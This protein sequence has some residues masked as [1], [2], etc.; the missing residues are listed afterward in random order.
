MKIPKISII[1]VSYNADQYIERTINSIVNQ[2][3]TDIEYLIIDGGSTDNT[4]LIIDKYKNHVDIL[5]SEPDKGLYDAMNKGINIAS[6]EYINFMNAG[7]TFYDNNTLE[8]V[9]KNSSGEDFL[10][11]DTIIIN[12]V[13]QTRPLHKKKPN[14]KS[15][16]YKSFIKGMIICHQ[17]M[18]I[19]KECMVQYDYSKYKLACD[20]EWAIKTSKNCTSFKDAGVYIAKFLDGGVSRNNVWRAVKERFWI[21]VDH[22]GF[23]NTI[24]EQFTILGEYIINRYKKTHRYEI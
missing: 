11:G 24:F 21:S 7:D 22:Y 18:I 5:V 6:G 12:E 3:Y 8:N 10:Y 19:K 23:I 9:F 1:T 2:S 4:L 20:I 13:G 15:L 14:Q 17:S 16:N